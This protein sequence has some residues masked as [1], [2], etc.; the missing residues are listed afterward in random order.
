MRGLA[1]S[2]LIRPLRLMKTILLRCWFAFLFVVVGREVRALTVTEP[3]DF[4]NDA[5]SAAT[6]VLDV[7]GND[8][9]GAI[10]GGDDDFFK[11][12]VLPGR[13]ITAIQTSGSASTT[14]TVPLYAGTYTFFH[15]SPVLPGNEEW[16]FTFVV[17][18]APDY[19]ISTT[20]GQMVVTDRSGYG[21][22]LTVSEPFA[23]TIRFAAPGRTFSLNGAAFT[24]G[25]SG[26]IVHTSMASI[27]V[28]AGAGS[29]TINVGAFSSQLPTLTL[30]GGTGDDTV[31]FLGSIN[32]IPGM[33]LD[34]DLQNDDT[35]PGVDSVN[36][37]AGAQLYV[38]DGPIVVKCSRS[39]SLGNGAA[40]FS[41]FAPIIVEANQQEPATTGNFIGVNLA[42]ASLQAGEE[43]VTVR[44]RGGND[45]GGFQ[46]GVQVASGGK[47]HGPRG[48]TVV[49]T[50]G[51]SAGIVNRGVTVNG[52]GSAIESYTGTLSVTGTGGPVGGNFGIGVSLLFGGVIRSTSTAGITVTGTGAGA[53]GSS[54][55]HGI[56]M[57]GAGTAITAGR[58]DVAVRGIAGPGGSVGV[59]LNNS[60]AISTPLDG[61]DIAVTTDSLAIGSTSH[62]TAAD[63]ARAVLLFADSPSTVMDVGGENAPGRLGLSDAK[64]DRI[65]ARNLRVTHAGTGDIE[66]TAPITR[67]AATS[68]ELL[69]SDTAAIRAPGAGIDLS[70]AGGTLT[71]AIGPSSNE[72]PLA[73]PI[74]GAAADTGYPRLSVVGRVNLNGRR[75]ELTGTTFAGTAGQTFTLV[76]N[77]GTDPIV[78]AFGDLPEGATLA[79]PGSTL[80]NARIS[81]VGGSGNDVVL[82]LV[83]ALEVT[84]AGN[85]GIGSLRD[86]LAYAQSKP[87]ADTVTFAPELSGGVILLDPEIVS[88]DTEGVT[89]D[90]SS[91]PAVLTIGGAPD[92]NRHFSVSS[93]KSLA[94]LGLRLIGGKAGG[95]TQ[96]GNGNSIANFGTLALTRCIFTANNRPNGGSGGAIL[97]DGGTLTA[98]Q[99]TFSGNSTTNGGA[100]YQTTGSMTLTQ[101]TLAANTVGSAGD[102]GAIFK[103]AGTATLTHCTLSGNQ[104]ATVGGDGGAISQ[105]D[106]TLALTHCTLSGNQAEEGGAISIY[107]GTLTLA[108]SIIAGNTAI[109]PGSD[110]DNQQGDIIG[111]GK[112]IVQSIG[113]GLGSTL[114]GNFPNAAPLLAPLDYY[115]GPT[116]TMALLPGSPARDAATGSSN[117]A[118]QRGQ[119]MVGTPDLGAYE[120]GVPRNYAAWKYE[121]LPAATTLAERAPGFDFDGDGRLNVL[122]YA[123]FTDGTVPGG[124]TGTTLVRQPDGSEARFTFTVNSFATDLLYELQR[125]LPG[126][127]PWVTIGDVNLR[128]GLTHNYGVGVT[129][130]PGF[131]SIEFRDPGIAGQP[132][133]FYR[134][135]VSVP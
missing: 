72:S 68:L 8:F 11:V 57:G 35:S 107:D 90:A 28:N 99:C 55:N 32:F 20:G 120:A 65:V 30:N 15:I 77:D 111:V 110:I 48:A 109:D 131:F 101:C 74:T 4:P 51:A 100:I 45:A 64:L 66:I 9:V 119:P 59:S 67:A 34:V 53:P 47:I 14:L 121:T 22:T 25:D 44:G 70:L 128:T 56:E 117:T 13:K 123:T 52:A 83:S 54:V 49:G 63:A 37:A 42:G 19:E 75:L 103:E 95:A 23:D 39:V 87:G 118:D 105:I 31:N 1:E 94:L 133:A 124:S 17:A 132:K 79:W 43:T 26:A 85:S 5:A 50:G 98:T 78:G 16:G 21:D 97:N 116:P 76:E 134:L 86:V 10:G 6:Y 91:L 106:G 82:R 61:G 80:L 122:E 60:A 84:N 7:G 89:V 36:V 12:T 27:T 73:M 115:G 125:S 88:D 112:N 135:Q 126:V 71:L 3:P 108:H 62:I 24:T 96:N 93:G 29:D 129:N 40:L 38:V 18:A 81:Y 33:T 41:L 104:A 114:S 2:R 69:C 102:G 130:V 46:L 58:G 127:G 92:G 113:L